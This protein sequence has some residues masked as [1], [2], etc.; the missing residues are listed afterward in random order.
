MSTVVSV[1]YLNLGTRSVGRDTDKGRRG[2][3]GW[4]VVV[5][6]KCGAPPTLGV[7]TVATVREE[8]N[9]ATRTEEA[10]TGAH[11]DAEVV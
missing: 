1:R 3:V 9:L 8:V 2:G 11:R 10:V 6:W 5:L 4:G 7:E